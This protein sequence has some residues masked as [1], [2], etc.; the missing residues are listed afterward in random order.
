VSLYKNKDEQ[1]SEKVRQANLRAQNEAAL[2][3]LSKYKLNVVVGA[4]V[5]VLETVSQVRAR[6]T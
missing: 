6:A 1:T 2:L 3:E 4:L 5:Q